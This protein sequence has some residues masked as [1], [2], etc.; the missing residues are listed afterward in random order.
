MK[1]FLLKVIL[2]IIPFLLISL[3]PIIILKYSGENFTNIKPLVKSNHKHLIGYAYNE[4]N[5]G[6]LKWIKIIENPKY[7]VWSL[8]S[9]RVLQF[10]EEMFSKSFYNVGFTISKISDFYAFFQSLPKEKYPKY[11]IIGLD[12]W[13][14]NKNWDSG[15]EISVKANWP[16]SFTYFPKFK[17]LIKCYKDLK[18]GKYGFNVIKNN[19]Q[20]I[21]IGLNAR[22][23][24]KGIRNDGSMFYG[25]Q[26]NKLINNDK[27]VD[28][29]KFYDTYSR[30]NNGNRRFQYGNKINPIAI[31]KLNQ[32][33]SFCKIHKIDVI[34]F[35]PPFA[36]SVYKKMIMS[37]NYKYLDNLST[38]LIPLFKKYDFEFY[39]YSTVQQLN[40]TDLY[41]IDGFHG[42][43][44]VYFNILIDMSR[45]NSLIND[46]CDPKKMKSDENNKNNRYIIY[47]Y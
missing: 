9:S 17:T 16:R 32:F 26:I 27:S 12:Q 39:N 5:Y 23:N 19:S 13:M 37:N 18:K 42:G 11:L 29:Y 47:K 45:N 22:V 24:N 15:R 14:F 36:N 46:I 35:L 7:D 34:G 8:G 4:N 30:I 43:E 28:D 6:Y 38:E 44:V 2:F 31:S 25:T 10:R 40:L 20:I 1:R 41:F 3:P 21:K 33:L